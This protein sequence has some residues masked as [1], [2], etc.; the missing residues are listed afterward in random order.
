MAITLDTYLEADNLQAIADL[1]I[2]ELARRPDSGAPTDTTNL[3][4]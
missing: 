1:I 3:F 2:F 4:Y